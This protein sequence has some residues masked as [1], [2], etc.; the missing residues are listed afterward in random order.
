M[1]GWRDFLSYVGVFVGVGEIIRISR[2]F[3]RVIVGRLRG[4]LGFRCLRLG[5]DGE[6][7]GGRSWK[8]LRVF[9]YFCFF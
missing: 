4:R 3:F 5:D 9:V 2:G 6:F 8:G 7:L 1:G